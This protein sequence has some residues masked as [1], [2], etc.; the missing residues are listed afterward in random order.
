M[1]LFETLWPTSFACNAS[2]IIAL[3]VSA[4]VPRVRDGRSVHVVVVLLPGIK[5]GLQI[6]VSLTTNG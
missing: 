1:P 2:V 3:F 5:H 4:S 6:A